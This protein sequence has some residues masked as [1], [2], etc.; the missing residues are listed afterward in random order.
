MRT[1]F[2]LAFLVAPNLA[3]SQTLAFTAQTGGDEAVTGFKNGG[4]SFGDLNNDG[5]LD[6]LVNRDGSGGVILIND[7]SG[8]FSQDASVPSQLSNDR[9]RTALIGDFNNDGCNDFIRNTSGALDVFR[10]NCDSAT[11]PSFT[12]SQALNDT[13]TETYFNTEGLA[14]VDVNDDGWLDLVADNH[15]GVLIFQNKNGVFGDEDGV[16][17]KPIDS[18]RVGIPHSGQSDESDYLVATDLNQDGFT[19]LL[20]RRRDSN[21]T[22]E[23]D[24]F[25][26]TGSHTP[27]FTE[28]TTQSWNIDGYNSDK[29]GNLACDFDDDGDFDLWVGEGVNSSP[30]NQIL[31]ND[32][33]GDFT[34][35]SA[36]YPE[37]DD[38][39]VDGADCIDI[40]N[41]GDLDLFISD[42]DRD[43]LY[44]NP[45][46]GSLNDF[47]LYSGTNS[48]FGG[49][50]SEGIAAAD[51]DKDGDIDLYINDTATNELWI[52][53]LN[54]NAPAGTGDYLV[55]QPLVQVGTCPGSTY[56]IPYGAVVRLRA[57]DGGSVGDYLTGAR[58]LN[59][60]KGHGGMGAPEIHFG[61]STFG[62][63]DNDYWLEISYPGGSG[64]TVTFP[65]HPS[66]IDGYNVLQVRDDDADGDGI[67]DVVEKADQVT[68]GSDIDN[69]G[70][71]N[72]Q[73]PDSDNDGYPDG[74]PLE[75]N[76]EDL[77]SATTLDDDSDSKLDYLD[78]LLPTIYPTDTHPVVNANGKPVV[79]GTLNPNFSDLE[80]TVNGT[81]YDS[82][83]S[84]LFVAGSDWILNLTGLST[85]LPED[86]YDIEASQNSGVLTDSTINELVVDDTPPEVSVDDLLTNSSQP[87][88]TGTYD[89]ADLGPDDTDL[90]VT[91][92]NETYD[93]GD[94]ALTIES[95]VWTLDLADASQTLT[96]DTYDV[97]A[98]QTD[99]AGNEGEDPT[100]GELEVDLTPPDIPTVTEVKSKVSQP[101]LTGSYDTDADMVTVTIDN[102]TYTSP[103]GDL[104]LLSGTW[105]L[106][107][108]DTSQT[109]DDGTYDVEITT[110]DAAGNSSDDET[111]LEVVVDT[112]VPTVTVNDLVTNNDQPNLTGTYDS[113]DLGPDADDFTVFI[114]GTTHDLSGGDLSLNS[115]TDTWTLSLSGA[116]QSLDDGTYSVVTTQSDFVGNEGTDPSS[117][118]VTI[119]TTAPNAPT[120]NPLATSDDEPTLTG[121]YDESDL[122]SGDEDLQVTVDEI[123]YDLGDSALTVNGSGTWTLNLG[124]SSHTLDDNTYDVDVVQMDDVGNTASDNTDD[125]LT[126]DAT[127]P[128]VPTVDAQY[129]NTG[130]PTL[131]GGF[132]PD[133]LETLE[134]TVNETTYDLSDSRLSTNGSSWTLNLSAISPLGEDVYNVTAK[135]TDALGLSSTDETSGELTVDLTAP[136]PTADI[137]TDDTGKPTLTGDYDKDDLD[138]LTVLVGG[139]LYDLDDDELTVDGSGTWTL[140]LEDISSPFSDGTHDV[141]VTQTD[142]A[143]NVGVDTTDNELV[144]D[145]STPDTDPP[146]VPT[147]DSLLTNEPQPA[148]T[149][150]YDATDF[151]GANADLLVKV[152]TITYD[153]SDDALTIDGIGGWTLDLSEASH[154]LA[155]D[156]Y[157]VTVTSADAAGNTADDET[158][159]EVTVDTTPPATPTVN[160]LLSASGKPVLTGTYEDDD[161]DAFEVTVDGVTYDT[162][163]GEL[164]LTSGDWELDL[165]GLASP[166]DDDLYDVVATQSDS[167]G[168]TASDD[169]SDELTVDSTASG[170]PTVAVQL[171]ATNKPVL[172]GSYDADNLGPDDGDLSI[173]VDGST[174]DLGDAAFSVNGTGGWTL[175]LK[176]AGQK[177]QDDVY[178]VSITQTDPADNQASDTTSDEV[179]IDT[180]PPDAPTVDDVHDN[181]GKP[182]LTGGYDDGDFGDL[183]VTVNG[184]VYTLD[185]PELS[186]DGSGGWELDLSE[187]PTPLSDGPYDVE[188]T[189]S[190]LAGNTADDATSD[191]LLID[192]TPPNVPTVDSLLTNN[193]RPQLTGDYD[194][195]DLDTLQVS[196]D[197]STYDQDD[198]EL[199]LDGIGGWTLDLDVASHKLDED[200][201]DVAVMQTD[202]AG[203]SA[204]DVSNDEVEIDITPPGAPTVD[205]ATSVDGRPILSGTYDDSDT[206]GLTVE[207]NGTTYVLGADD[208]LT[209]DGSGGW[210]LDLSGLPIALSPETYDVTAT[211]WDDA[212]NESTDDTSGELEVGSTGPD[213]DGDGLTDEEEKLI[214]GTDPLDP[215]SDNDGLT[216]GDEVL[217]HGTA[218]LDP[219]SDNDGLSDGDEVND[220][221]TDPL[222]PDTDDDDLGDGQEVSTWSTDPLDKDTD[223]DGLF[224]GSEVNEHGTQPLRPDT[225]FDGLT[226]AEEV[227]TT[228]T[229]PNDPDSDDDGLTDGD[230]VNLHDTDP[231]DPDTDDGGV[232]DGHEVLIEGTDPLDPSDDSATPSDD[233][234]NDGL[235]DDEEELIYG[236]D[237]NDPDTD[238]DGL[239]DGEEV[240]EEGTDPQ[241]PDT[242]G[243][244]LSDGDEV[245]VHVTDPLDPDTDDDGLTDGE[246]VLDTLTDPDDPDTDND[247]LS[248]GDEVGLWDTDPLDD[249]TDDDDL[250]DGVEA[251]TTDTDPNDP[252]SDNDGLTDGEEVGIH[253]TNPNDWDTDDGGVGDG[254]EVDQGTDPLDGN[255]D[256]DDLTDTDGDGLTD[257]EED[258]LG[259]DPNDPDTDSDGLTDGEEVRDHGTDPNDPDTD[260]DGLSDGD[261]VDGTTDPNDA[262]TDDDGLSDGEELDGADG[263]PNSGDET[264]P[265]DPDTDGDG[266]SD[267]EEL[268]VYDTDP[269]DPDT[270]ND[271]LTDGEEIVEHGTDPTNADT[272]GGSESDGDEVDQ[273]KDPLDETDDVP[274][275]DDRDGDGLT[276]DEE[277]ALGT[278]PDDP[279]TDGDGLTDGEEV[280][281]FDTDPNDDDTDDDGLTDGEEVNDYG[282]DP[283]DAD[284][285][286]DGLTDGEEVNDYGTDPNDPDTDGGGILDGQEVK[287]GNDPTASGDDT[288]VNV[289]TEYKGHFCG[290]L[291]GGPQGG[292]MA[293]LLVLAAVGSRRAHAQEV[294]NL[295]VQN[296]RMPVDSEMTLYADDAGVA[297]EW[298]PTGR[299]IMGYMNGPIGVVTLEDGSRATILRDALAANLVGGISYDRFRLGADVPVYFFSSSQVVTSATGGIGDI[300]LDLKT[301]LLDQADNDAQMGMAVA[302]RSSFPTASVQTPLGGANTAWEISAIADKHFGTKGLLALNLGYR[303]GP[304]EAVAN[305]DYNDQVTFRLGGG[306]AVSDAAGLSLDVAGRYDYRQGF[307]AGV[308]MPLEVLAGGWGRLSDTDWTV[309]G[310]AGTGLTQGIGAPLARVIAGIAYEPNRR[311]VDTDGDGYFDSVDACPLQ[312]EDFDQFEDEEGCP[313]P[314]NDRD[315]ILDVY[316]ECP[317]IPEDADCWR[318]DDGCPD[319]NAEVHFIV[320]NPQG[321][322]IPEATATVGVGETLQQG[323]GDFVLELA[324][325]VWPFTAAA[326]GFAFNATDITVRNGPPVE[327]ILVLQPAPHTGKL[328]IVVI[329]T[330]GERISDAIWTTAETG[331]AL[332][333]QGAVQVDSARYDITVRAPGFKP[334]D[335]QRA[336]V[337][338]DQITKVV[339]ILEPSNVQVTGQT[340][341]IGDRVY[342]DTSKASIQTR[343][344]GLLNEIAQILIDHPELLKVRI[345]GHTDSRGGAES[346][347]RLSDA[348]AASVREYL[349][350]RGVD[351]ARLESKGYGESKPLDPAENAQAWEKNR[352]V[353]FFIVER[354]D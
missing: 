102:I 225:D 287:D 118:E 55:V 144:V 2:L 305:I 324:P 208:E 288:N 95:G 153:L 7:Q 142:L 272:D 152:D 56:R 50:N 90:T 345:E 66:D 11:D 136:T 45:G 174:Y 60:G 72:W 131:T 143:G 21:S 199:T 155:D 135:Q 46:D 302:L 86:L 35:L 251:L 85:P 192:T 280:N 141:T 125:E 274:A 256:D 120:V 353:D 293:L 227:L 176:A 114:N 164:T 112:D 214:T 19:D 261:E 147:V 132:D 215:D 18:T 297:G 294:P 268:T 322:V 73:D 241:K 204:S 193:Q 220:H 77:C 27:M 128:G 313:D 334:S 296:W 222:N 126:V 156:D 282:T 169:T 179:T 8:G 32:G 219:D 254:V 224:D 101:P 189:Q 166:M 323:D 91:V 235:T 328:Q 286:D 304:S 265:N 5:W 67:S 121:S 312:P 137:I 3:W 245:L 76:N 190:D 151:G 123:T 33:S 194:P 275:D 351:K 350:K 30:H 146:A 160:S 209:A 338:D 242:D 26:G 228:D 139:Q 63:E 216:D 310:G 298:T 23:R 49:G 9:E 258:Y 115:F 200:V 48:S 38:S 290:Y 6:L 205:P 318:D 341:D 342:F 236:T 124:T 130:R 69:D 52:N 65:V 266:L 167:A 226:D 346:N 36:Q 191:E 16:A 116:G 37:R 54:D 352:R 64:A 244:G 237:P 201:Y 108:E 347:Q 211:A 51:Y 140:D 271:G 97:T 84:Q 291:P 321:E 217:D 319:P 104:E 1:P 15:Q 93:L 31:E 149:G 74:D 148:L 47:D 314:D 262:D 163:D 223:D 92:D 327:A 13:V 325:A 300:S 303:G 80:V 145:T 22:K 10:S 171:H 34:V 202:P 281:D 267:G 309:R 330:D 111:A 71:E 88:L 17:G 289:A 181:T 279:D 301:A 20:L 183:T 212:G 198:D 213:T 122:G 333:P 283:N 103:H 177:L 320:H 99:L 12:R 250:K 138:T 165:S 218:P 252:D 110:T 315:G 311:D 89:P 182:V 119:D 57:D 269:N 239:T 299:F 41:D 94:S 230:E 317:M 233:T 58:E 197:G 187:L 79:T 354:A 82:G 247:G 308:G 154:T 61:L 78:A 195:D 113:D 232:Q 278:D 284:T 168:N 14:W 263:T 161:V 180:T 238:G 75:S 203:N 96:E 336:V 105:L 158:S 173:T 53:T 292:L 329:D 42:E 70:L 316:D 249:D 229:D 39:E 240:M 259:T 107:L 243:D 100:S 186:V 127:P 83:D 68:Y 339:F 270:D 337:A 185:D 87:T 285:D 133:D 343:S 178:D 253:E 331:D 210:I 29:G 246:E 28:D 175:D 98:V 276:N 172:T 306:Y 106:H 150:T 129:D 273:G 264:D 234:D 24:L 260:D 43:W 257:N 44:L 196:V 255:D 206:D 349:T 248:D 81:T 59:S 332:V 335:K 157:D 344:F 4:A 340:I 25:W 326:P 170:V 162:D 109:L 277:E 134:I 348:R 184:I 231:N 295:D 117:D 188:V 40:D 62:G 221:F 207:V 159:D 307:E